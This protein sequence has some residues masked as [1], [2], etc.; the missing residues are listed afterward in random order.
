VKTLSLDKEKPSVS[1]VIPCLNE[2][3]FISKCFDSIIANDYPNDRLEILVVD[4]MSEDGTRQI[5]REY[6]Q[7]YPFIT[8]VAM[9]IGIKNAKFDIIIRMDAHSTYEKEYIAKCVKYLDEYN[10]DN[11]GGM[12]RFVPRDDTAIAKA[13]AIASCHPFGGGNAYYRVGS[14]K[15]RWVDTVL[16]GC[17][18]RRVFE[19][20]GFYNENLKRN[21]DLELNLRLKRAG[22]KIL[23]HP[24]IEFYYY[25]R[26]DLKS[27]FRH[28]LVDGFW[29]LFSLRFINKPLALRQYIPL[30][31]VS[32]LIVSL[33]LSLLHPFFS[34]L[35][36]FIIGLYT[37]VDIYHSLRIAAREKDVRCFPAMLIVFP[38]LH[39]GYGLGS[40][41]I[42]P[43]LLMSKDFWVNQLNLRRWFQEI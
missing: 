11:V 23:L 36:L 16:Y 40:L 26:S 12:M 19:K 33:V 31:F 38:A 7:Q 25:T 42:L 35:L 4:G 1:I 17:Y 5:V 22:G 21:Q 29:A 37:L 9:N 41:Y 28:R 43:R 39:V 34:W 13:I 10:A 6:A 32:G 3:R 27:V 2:E 18:R 20:I 14:R 15:P 24:A 30:V 8:P